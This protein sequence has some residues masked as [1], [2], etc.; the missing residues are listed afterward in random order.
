MFVK[1]KFTI[2]ND[3]QVFAII[4]NAKVYFLVYFSWL[5]SFFFFFYEQY[6]SI[7]LSL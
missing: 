5:I 1:I 2:K 4:L 7:L 3:I 6:S